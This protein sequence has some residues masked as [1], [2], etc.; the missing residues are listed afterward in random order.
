MMERPEALKLLSK[1][2]TDELVIT[3]MTVAGEWPLISNNDPLDFNM[4]ESAMG[5]APSIGLGV[6]L[7]QP[8]RKVWV[9]NGDGSQLMNLGSLGS[10]GNAGV[11]NLIVFVFQNDSYE[12]TGGQ[13]I[14]LAGRVDFTMVA[15]GLGVRNSYSFD[16]ISDLEAKLP[17]IL[18]E[19]GPTLV[20]LHVVSGNAPVAP[21]PDRVEEARKFQRALE[22]VG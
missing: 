19:A 8:D 21:R 3:T 9:L 2:R 17:A 1:H 16:E 18:K 6:A 5:R 20:V 4:R 22:V 14:P 12:V 10:I 11:G 7:A 15:K 13:P